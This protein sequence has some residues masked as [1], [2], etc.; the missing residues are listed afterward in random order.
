MANNNWLPQ[1]H[2]P[3][4]WHRPPPIF[5]PH[6]PLDVRT[7][8][9]RPDAFDEWAINPSDE[10][11]RQVFVIAALLLAACVLTLVVSPIFGICAAGLTAGA[12]A[13][14]THLKRR[15]DLDEAWPFREDLLRPHVDL[16]Q[17]GQAMVGWV[18]QAIGQVSG[19]R[20]AREGHLPGWEGLLE[21]QRWRIAKAAADLTT[22]RRL[23]GPG[24]AILAEQVG[25]ADATAAAIEQRVGEVMRFAASVQEVDEALAVR[26]A[27]LR[28]EEIDESLLTAYAAASDETT[29]RQL[30]E[31]VRQAQAGVD[32]AVEALRFLE[33]S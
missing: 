32:A 23:I 12:V 13:A 18:N 26:D 31:L 15:H 7:T 33:R 8:L 28:R 4:P 20:A 2:V 5:A 21:D 17:F 6:V 10:P 29:G 25:T 16:D 3:A 9:A 24:A 1:T 27:V 11:L 14:V 30:D 22:A 19:S